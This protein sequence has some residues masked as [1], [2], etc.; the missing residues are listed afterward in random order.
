MRLHCHGL[1]ELYTNIQHIMTQRKQ[2]VDDVYCMK[3]DFVQLVRKT[4]YND[5]RFVINQL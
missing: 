3:L 1:D 4:E 5:H 2:T